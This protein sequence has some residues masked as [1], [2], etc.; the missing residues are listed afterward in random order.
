MENNNNTLW[1]GWISRNP[2]FVLPELLSTYLCRAWDWGCWWPCCSHEFSITRIYFFF[3]FWEAIKTSIQQ[4]KNQQDLLKSR[5]YIVMPSLFFS[6]WN[7]ITGTRWNYLWSCPRTAN[8]VVVSQ[9]GTRFTLDFMTFSP[10]LRR[11]R[12]DDSGLDHT[13]RVQK[14]R[15]LESEMDLIGHP[16]SHPYSYPRILSDNLCLGFYK[17]HHDRHDYVS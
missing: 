9:E 7:F 14:S 2:N 8:G 12:Q 11:Q 4:E 17:I 15:F 3:C 6:T 13:N 16:E 1:T 5:I 10:L